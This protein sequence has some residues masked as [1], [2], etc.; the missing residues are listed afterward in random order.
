MAEKPDDN[1]SAFL[2]PTNVEEEPL[3]SEQPIPCMSDIDLQNDPDYQCDQNEIDEIYKNCEQFQFNIILAGITG[4]GKSSLANA[5]VGS[6]KKEAFREGACLDHC[7]NH[8]LNGKSERMKNLRVWDTPGLF[9]GTNRDTK[10]LNEM[11]CVLKEIKQGDVLVLCI[12]TKARFKKGNEDIQALIKLKKK[13]G[14]GVLEK[15]MVIALTHVDSIAGRACGRDPAQYYRERI[16][17]YKEK[18][19]EALEK[20]VRFSHTAA[21]EIKIFPVQHIS[22]G[23][24]LPDQ[25]R[26]LSNFWCGCFFTISNIYAQAS[27]LIHF[28][29]RFVDTPNPNPEIAD[30]QLVLCD[31]FLPEKL[32]E[33]KSKY[34][35]KGGLIGI[36]GGPLM[37]ITIPM[38]VWAGGRHGEKKYLKSITVHKS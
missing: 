6:D 32:L 9:D 15:H 24:L 22:K 10:Y 25:T 7:T 21:K 23:P 16:E 4:A 36:L 3:A 33:M 34:K 35:V 29:D 12:E 26:W 8:V 19:R 14:L 5:I 30:T 20:D 1:E 31:K 2:Q 28:R 18:I 27:W 11:D 13:F 37:L 17:E 38:G